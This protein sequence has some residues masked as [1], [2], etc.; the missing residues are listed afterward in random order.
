MCVEGAASR[1]AW[2]VMRAG[3]VCRG[4]GLH[5]AP[6]SFIPAV[7]YWRTMAGGACCCLFPLAA[8]VCCA[9]SAAAPL[10]LLAVTAAQSATVHCHCRSSTW[11]SPH[12]SAA[13]AA[14]RSEA[15]A[16]AMNA[17]GSSRACLTLLLAGAAAAPCT[18][19]AAPPAAAAAKGSRCRLD[20]T[21]RLTPV[22]V[23]CEIG[24]RCCL[25]WCRACA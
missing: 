14:A 15:A 2:R 24:L 3:Q 5:P 18:G 16:V 17:S 20:M 25:C 12:P 13:S 7:W 19:D 4:N 21:A 10:L 11:L 8:W 9:A 23:S 6:T 22:T 1:L